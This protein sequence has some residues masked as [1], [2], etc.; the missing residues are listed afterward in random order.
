MKLLL[1]SY[2]LMTSF[3]LSACGTNGEAR[4]P[5]TLDQDNNRDDDHDHDDHDHGGLNLNRFQMVFEG[6]DPVGGE[7]VLGINFGS[8]NSV[9]AETSF[10]H[11]GHGAG[12]LS[13]MP[14][15]DP[16]RILGNSSTGRISISLSSPSQNIQ[17]ASSYAVAYMHNDHEDRGY[18]QNLVRIK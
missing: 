3:L 6:Q 16:S 18:C 7:C 2:A 14:S 8:N 11:G 9:S 13:L 17:D 15:N 12:T 1:L 4:D 5:Q 10:S